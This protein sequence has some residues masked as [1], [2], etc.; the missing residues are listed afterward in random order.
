MSDLFH[1]INLG[2]GCFFVCYNGKN[3]AFAVANH[4]LAGIHD[5]RPSPIRD[6]AGDLVSEQVILW[7]GLSLSWT[8][9]IMEGSN[10][11]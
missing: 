8:A 10:I 2:G 4:L 11:S 7:E 5:Q 1:S 9:T 6:K 3:V